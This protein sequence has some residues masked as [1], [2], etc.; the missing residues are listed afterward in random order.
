[1]ITTVEA[2]KQTEERVTIGIVSITVAGERTLTEFPIIFNCLTINI[3]AK[4]AGTQPDTGDTTE[5]A[6]AREHKKRAAISASRALHKTNEDT[7]VQLL[8]DGQH[9]CQLTEYTQPVKTSISYVYRH[10]ID[11]IEDCLRT[12]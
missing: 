6:N 3:N 1:M 5:C 4:S 2:M 10:F 7:P 12:L 11:C 8:T 9:Y